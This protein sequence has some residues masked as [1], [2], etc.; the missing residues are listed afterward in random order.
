VCITVD[1]TEKAGNMELILRLLGEC[2][3]RYCGLNIISLSYDKKKYTDP[4]CFT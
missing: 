1:M 2:V 4:R 3:G